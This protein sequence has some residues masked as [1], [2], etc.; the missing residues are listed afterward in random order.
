MSGF[1]RVVTVIVLF[2]IILFSIAVVVNKFLNLFEWAKISN[3]IIG[4]LAELNIYLMGGIL[5]AVFAACIVLLVYEFKKS[6]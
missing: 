2:K 3:K 6:S 1:N 4:F 5:L